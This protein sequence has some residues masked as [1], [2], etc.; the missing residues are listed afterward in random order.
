MTDLLLYDG[1]CGLCDRLNRFV[2]ARDRRDRIVFAPLQGSVARAILARHGRDATALDT[3][4][5][6][7]D[8]EGPAERVLSRAR[9]VLFLLESLGGIWGL[10][11]VVERLPSRWLD[12]A[13][14]LVAGR[15]YRWFGRSE[16][17]IVPPAGHR[18][19]FLGDPGAGSR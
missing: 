4:Y 12:G 1:V 3:V 16:A 7:A 5:V 2:L 15:R 11:R 19:K 17:C 8:L 9:A 10:A 18:A 6:V 13:Y 14:D